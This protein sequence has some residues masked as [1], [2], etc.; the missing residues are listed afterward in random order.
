MVN[1]GWRL[2]SLDRKLLR[3]LWEMKGQA[4]AIATVIAAG[5][6]MFVTYLSNF[7]SLQRTRDVYY[8][9]QRFADVF[10]GA[11]RVPQ[12]AAERIAAT[13]G[14]SAV[15]TR[16]VVDVALD[17]PGMAEPATGR[18]ISIP[19]RSQPLLN[20]VYLRSGRWP[21]PSKPDEV[22]ASEPFCEAHGF[23][24]GSR[25]AAIINGRR[26]ALTIAGIALSPEYVYSIRP[27]EMIPDNRRF[28]V[29][30][31]ERRALA[32][33]FDMEGGFNDVAVKLARGANADEVIV[34][35]DR[36]LEPYGGRGAFPRSLQISAWTLANEFEQLKTFGFI[37]PLIFLGVAAFILN[38]A[39]ARALALQRPQIAAL[40]ALGYSNAALACHYIKWA[41]VIAAFG[42]LAGAALGG[43]LGSLL[44][45]LY[46][47]FF[48]FPVLDYHLSGG[49]AVASVALSLAAG[50]LGAQSAVRRAVTVPPAEA[51]RPEAPARYRR[52]LVERWRL[53][54]RLSQTTRMVLR[55]VERHPIRSAM[56]IVGIA[57]AGAVL[58]I[59]LAFIDVMDVLIDEQFTLTMRQSAT[60]SFVQPRSAEAV[61]AMQRL[62]GVGRVEPMRIVAARLRVGAQHRTLAI[63]GLTPD[64]TLARVVERSGREIALPPEGL[65]LSKMLADRL[66][67]GAGGLVR[68]ETL[69]GTRPTRNVRVAAL[70]DDSVGLQAYMAIDALRRLMHEG[71]TVSAVALAADPAV[72]RTLYARLKGLPAVAGVAVRELTLQNFRDIMAQNMNLQIFINVF[73]SAVIAFGVVYNS[74]RVSLSER[75]HELASLRVL[76]FTRAEISLVLLGELTLVTLLSLPLGSVIGYLFGLLIMTLFNNE[77]YR[78]PFTVTPQT[79]AWTWL[80]IIAAAAVSAFAVRRRLDRLDLVAVLKA[81][82]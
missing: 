52:S 4:L 35:L 78:L 42:A 19:G 26:R 17:V 80:T 74:A 59:G 72:Q 36:L 56:S 49:V 57:F 15:D 66:G 53:A 7:D 68:V 40:K 38:V 11:V 14:V 79:L 30:W 44:I 82:E 16:V 76:G 46:N 34:R 41:L 21:D 10:A 55:N 62:P 54:T 47:Q 60:V 18:L 63:T 37:I 48:R 1:R 61:Y 20:A 23:V 9:R 64:A 2:S 5:V 77:L 65:V 24:P 45:G 22:L 8:E 51:M 25:L 43:W 73:F 70:V 12:R 32:S 50:A 6:T 39:L 81:Q 75:S 29:F 13:P 71:E 69:E 27:G 28:G 3:D 67:V 33:A 31:M 58:L